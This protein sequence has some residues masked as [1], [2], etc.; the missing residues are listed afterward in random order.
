VRDDELM[1]RAIQLART[2]RR[3]TAPKP[4][5]G[6]VIVRDGEIVGTGATEPSPAGAHAEAVAL[7]EA[8]PRAVGATAYSTLEPC[9]HFGTTPPCADALVKAGIARV[10]V[11]VDDPDERVAGRGYAHLRNAGVEV[12]TG[13]GTL[14]ATRDLLPYLHHRRTGRAFV[15]AKVALSLDGRVAARDGSSKWITGPVARADAHELRADVQAIVVGAGTALADQPSLTV[16]DV[17]VP[18]LHPPLRVLLDA[19]GRVPA[20][21]PLFDV[22][23]APTL[24][25]TTDRAR[26]EAVDAWR[27]SG[28]KVETV[29]PALDGN[30]VD[31]EAVFAL[32]GAHGV[33]AALVEGGGQLLGSLVGTG[34]AHRLFAYVAPTLLGA[35]AQPGFVFAGPATIADADRYALTG[36]RQLGNDVRLEYDLREVAA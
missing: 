14:E 21:G 26:A 32:L 3:H 4:P 19:R 11:A 6:C 25:I 7:R 8:G 5:V 18:P 36:V 28:A 9:N 31:L 15:L 12:V 17:S 29:A 24:V 30:G 16:R 34:R 35:E 10:V 23:R 20:G 1:G 2:A 27:A 33:L 22:S 13:V